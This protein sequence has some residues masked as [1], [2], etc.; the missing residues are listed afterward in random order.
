MKDHNGNEVFV[1][2][3]KKERFLCR[4]E[5]ALRQSNS[6]IDPFHTQKKHKFFSFYQEIIFSLHKYNCF[7]CINRT[8]EVNVRLNI[9]HMAA[10]VSDFLFIFIFS[11]KLIS[12]FYFLLCEPINVLIEMW[13][14]A[15]VEFIEIDF[16]L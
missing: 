5:K 3:R 4:C 9:F 6:E 11:K 8:E 14:C 2:K 16:N 10:T 12:R 13:F 7:L 15:H 1:S